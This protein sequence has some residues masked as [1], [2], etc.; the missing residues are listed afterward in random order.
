MSDEK[1]MKIAIKEALKGDYP[2]GAVIVKNEKVIAKSHNTAKNLDPTAH[3]EVNV[4]RNACKKLKSRHLEG[5]VLYTTCEPCP[6]CFIAAWWARIPKIVYGVEGNSVPEDEW[7]IDINCKYLNEK[8][9]NK[10]ELKNGILKEEC[11]KLLK[12]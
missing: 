1:F 7:K 8:S 6:M 9:R 5:C 11:L 2:F 10:I 3:A 12:Q 4:T